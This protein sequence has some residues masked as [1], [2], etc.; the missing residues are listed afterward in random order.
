VADTDTGAAEDK[1]E[2]TRIEFRSD[3]PVGKGLPRRPDVVSRIPR[4]IV[5][6]RLL[7]PAG[8]AGASRSARVGRDEQVNERERC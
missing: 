2:N 5:Q 6:L 4:M 7:V 1:P 3:Y 8:H